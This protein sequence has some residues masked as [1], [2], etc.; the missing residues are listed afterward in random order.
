MD[1]YNKNQ[2]KK[3]AKAPSAVGEQGKQVQLLLD[4]TDG[5]EEEHVP[6]GSRHTS[7]VVSDSIEQDGG[8]SGIVDG[9]GKVGSSTGTQTQ[10]KYT[11]GVQELA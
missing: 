3:R 6:T 8:R 7:V 10:D 2:V 11:K 1:C 5:Q 9:G 4:A